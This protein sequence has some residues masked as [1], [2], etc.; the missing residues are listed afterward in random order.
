MCKSASGI[1]CCVE[2]MCIVNPNWVAA[3]DVGED[4]DTV[5][6]TNVFDIWKL[7]RRTNH[8]I[9]A[10]VDDWLTIEPPPRDLMGS[11]TERVQCSAPMRLTCMK[12]SRYP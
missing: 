4:D 8:T 1:K 10:A 12:A 7:V 3:D 5:L 6:F 11:S 2:C 9:H